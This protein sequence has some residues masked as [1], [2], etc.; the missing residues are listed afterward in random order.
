M[1]ASLALLAAA[2]LS[3]VACSRPTQDDPPPPGSS[4]GPATSAAPI[5][6][7]SASIA[8]S[9]AP[10]PRNRKL[11]AL[12]SE[13]GTGEILTDKHIPEIWIPDVEPF[14]LAV[15]RGSLWWSD[16]SGIHERP[17]NGDL[18]PALP[19]LNVNWLVADDAGV[20]FAVPTDKNRFDLK[21]ISEGAPSPKRL[22]PMT[23]SP[24]RLALARDFAIVASTCG[25]FAVP[26]AGGAP[27]RLEPETHRDIS[28]AADRDLVCYQ[29]D[30]RLT[31]RSLVDTKA[32]PYVLDA[33]RPGPLLVD[34]LVLY[35]LE[36]ARLADV[37]IDGDYGRLVRWEIPTGERWVLTSKQFEAHT[38]LRDD[39]SI[40][41][42]TGAGSIRRIS[43]NGREV[44]TLY[45]ADHQE[46]PR[47]AIA[48][49]YI[50]FALYSERGI[51]RF[52]ANVEL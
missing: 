1:P 46:T 50:Y 29:N 3:L 39:R 26:R 49:G 8:S 48:A 21:Q 14:S 42:G 11:T 20:V 33:L 25:I 38:L 52:R 2:A 15:H 31:C 10:R 27:R 5:A 41:F 16:A 7:A 12:E 37:P 9:A 30:K 32:K 22:A 43:K 40:Y 34:R 6:S 28:I 51:R 4:A 13:T 47:L 35:A 23:C 24:L 36:E 19:E 45:N 18:K 44:Q 17:F